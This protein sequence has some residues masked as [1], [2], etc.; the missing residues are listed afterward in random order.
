M[1]AVALFVGTLAALA[2]I[3]GF[4][5]GQLW[6]LDTLANFRVQYMV[7]LF[8]AAIVLVILRDRRA[9]AWMAI[10]C[11]IDA[12][13]VMFLFVG[14]PAP[15]IGSAQLEIVTFNT[16]LLD[17]LPQLDWVL[18]HD[19]DVVLLF[20]SSRKAE[21]ELADLGGYVVTSGIAD[22]REFGPTVLTR[23]PVTVERV[24][25]SGSLGAALRFET[26][27]GDRMVA[28]YAVHPLS[29]TSAARTEAR[30]RDLEIVGRRIAAE[31]IPVIVAG[32]LNATPWSKGY[33]LLTDPAD[34]ATT[35]LGTGPGATW[36]AHVWWPLRI[37]LDHI[38]YSRDLTVTDREVGPAAAS[39]HLPV[40]AVIAA[41]DPSA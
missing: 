36:P 21:E 37:P 31:T 20:E 41:A 33:S 3:L 14:S 26:E 5:G 16:Q 2:T 19:P 24:L 8:G 13:L 40:R 6:M 4:F 28:V 18:Q 17:P 12:L 15:A 35:Q 1:R 32:D 10:A 9:A 23:E 7:I 39:D 34:L 38:L 22:E 30:N 25:D 29:P 11:A 27:I